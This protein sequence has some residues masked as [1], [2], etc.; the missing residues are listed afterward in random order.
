MKYFPQLICF[1]FP[2]LLSGQYSITG[3]L[4]EW[5]DWNYVH[6][7]YL[8]S[9][10]ELTGANMNNIVQS[11]KIDS[12]GHFEISGIGLPEGERLY[13]L[14][15][16]KREKGIGISSGPFVKSY[17][18]L[19]FSEPA[20]IELRC[21]D[22]S[23]SF[24]FCDIRNS[25]Q[26]AALARLTEHII[27]SLFEQFIKE[28]SPPSEIRKQFFHKKM[29]GVLKNFADTCQY[30][31][32]A[33]VALKKME[34]MEVDYKN[35]PVFY[36][37]FLK[38]LQPISESSPYAMEFSLLI[39]RYRRVNFGETKNWE[40]VLL[41]YSLLLSAL[42]LA[43]IFYLKKQIRAYKKQA[44]QQAITDGKTLDSLSAK[45]LEVFNLIAEGKSNKEIAQAL[46][47]ETSTVKTHVN[48]I[49]QKL[50]IR[51][52]KEAMGFANR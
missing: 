12:T 33:L 26:S 50:G 9:L 20:R 14:L 17:L 49:Y 7:Q 42:L 52:R 38:R 41:P 43:Y 16:G 28:G 36:E 2:L 25:P 1:L 24:S 4:K 51:S 18:Y 48:K 35:D 46:F 32:P 21:P 44:G 15:L 6:L 37:N 31:L 8:P 45:E 10:D 23:R 19:A 30:D 34:D 39:E 11:A 40:R 29:D 3:D 27:P 13:L 22:I 5:G 47:I